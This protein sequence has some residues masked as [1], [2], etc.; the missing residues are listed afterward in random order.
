M[1]LFCSVSVET[2]RDLDHSNNKVCRKSPGPSLG[3]PWRRIASWRVYI[4]IKGVLLQKIVCQEIVERRSGVASHCR[5][6]DRRRTFDGT[7][8]SFVLEKWNR[9]LAGDEV[10]DLCT[11]VRWDQ[12]SS[13]VYVLC[14]WVRYPLD[15]CWCPTFPS[16]CWVL[17]TGC[18]CGVEFVV[19]FIARKRLLST[20]KKAA[21]LDTGQLYSLLLK[22]SYSFIHSYSKK[23]N[24]GKP[25]L[26]SE[27]QPSLSLSSNC[28]SAMLKPYWTMDM[29]MDNF[30]SLCPFCDNFDPLLVF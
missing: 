19:L 10:S 24:K 21:F 17:I 8:R 11:G 4:R 16:T 18:Y 9:G 25:A 1:S 14:E 7:V 29:K 30:S 26:Y 23:A 13:G 12:E 28:F 6:V 5:G 15:H 22:F 3:L 2:I 20:A 27:V